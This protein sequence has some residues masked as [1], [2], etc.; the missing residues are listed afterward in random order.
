VLFCRTRLGRQ[1]TC[2][3]RA[4]AALRTVSS[5]YICACVFVRVFV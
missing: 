3:C 4:S 1:W 5:R 2:T